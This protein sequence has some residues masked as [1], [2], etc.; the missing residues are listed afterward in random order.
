MIINEQNEIKK[1]NKTLMEYRLKPGLKKSDF[2][3]LSKMEE[4]KYCD[5]DQ[6]GRVFGDLVVISQN[7]ITNML[8]CESRQTGKRYT[9]PIAFFETNTI[10]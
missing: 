1:N 2:A 6:V 3:M 9:Y 4:I 7:K 10:A 5:V 8:T